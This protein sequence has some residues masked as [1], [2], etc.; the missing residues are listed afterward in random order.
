MT[1]TVRALIEG[2]ELSFNGDMSFEAQSRDTYRIRPEYSGEWLHLLKQISFENGTSGV[3][4]RISGDVGLVTV[5]SEV[6]RSE[7]DVRC[8]VRGIGADGNVAMVTN[9]ERL[10]TV[11][12]RTNGIQ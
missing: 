9:T 3:C 7:G 11:M 6:L 12:S 1:K 8:F 4:R 2:Y 5:P 10:G